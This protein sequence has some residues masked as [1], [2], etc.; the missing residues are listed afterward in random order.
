MCGSIVLLTGLLISGT[1]CQVML[2]AFLYLNLLTLP[3]LCVYVSLLC[4]LLL[5]MRQC[6]L[7]PVCPDF[8]LNKWIWTWIHSPRLEEIRDMSAYTAEF[9]C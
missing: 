8:C 1:A 2:V 5:G 4:F 9:V 6:L 7:G 3:P